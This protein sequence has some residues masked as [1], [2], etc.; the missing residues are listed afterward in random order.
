MRVTRK[1]RAAV[2]VSD[3][4]N[5]DSLPTPRI[6]HLGSIT[7]LVQGRWSDNHLDAWN[8]YWYT[9]SGD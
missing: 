4:G 7:E 1:I 2:D 6:V 9:G 5:D 8:G 3:H